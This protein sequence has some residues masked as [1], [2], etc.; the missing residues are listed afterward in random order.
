MVLKLER[1]NIARGQSDALL[2][3]EIQKIGSGFLNWL[4]WEDFGYL[5]LF[6]R[7]GIVHSKLVSPSVSFP[8]GFSG[9]PHWIASSRE[10]NRDETATGRQERVLVQGKHSR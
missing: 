8:F 9:P 5:L 1:K 7:I 2:I 3:G 10:R 4:S 6:L